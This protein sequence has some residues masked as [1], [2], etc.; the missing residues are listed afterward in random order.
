M[1]RALI[2]LVSIS[3]A[4][5]TVW[6]ES[7][8]DM[9]LIGDARGHAGRAAAVGKCLVQTSKTVRRLARRLERS[10]PKRASLIRIQLVES[11][12]ALE[13]CND[14]PIPG[15]FPMSIGTP[16]PTPRAE[17]IQARKMRVFFGRIQIPPN[18][19]LSEKN[20]RREL[21]RRARQFANCVN[22]EQQI[23]PVISG[24]ALFQLTVRDGRVENVAQLESSIGSVELVNC[25]TRIFKRIRF[26]VTPRASVVQVPLS[27]KAID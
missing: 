15:R 5:S 21:R 17:S 9:S 22:R 23:H 27:F 3:L 4:P 24:S 11:L 2:L 12:T 8:D 13:R 10:R 7:Q 20:V 25:C 16:S 6:G 26:P 14:L 1:L 19:V 18:A